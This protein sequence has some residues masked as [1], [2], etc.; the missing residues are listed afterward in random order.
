METF[1]KSPGM[2]QSGVE[3]L[4][5]HDS[6]VCAVILTFNRLPM[7]QRC[8]AAVQNQTR[9]PDPVLVVDNHSSEVYTIWKFKG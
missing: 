4:P 6:R 7:L 3:T 2:T 1:E 9:R 8:L 5:A